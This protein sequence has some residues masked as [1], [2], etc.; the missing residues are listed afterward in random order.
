MTERS[1]HVPVC[2]QAISSRHAGRGGISGV[3]DQFRRP[4]GPG[5]ARQYGT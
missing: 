3:F 5:W 4:Y 2:R 1:S